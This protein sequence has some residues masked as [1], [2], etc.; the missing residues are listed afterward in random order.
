MGFVKFVRVQWD[1]VAGALCIVAGAVA[2]VVGWAQVSRSV[3]PAAQ[4]PY[5]VSCGVGGLFLLGVGA[6]LWL[7]ADLRDEWRHLDTLAD[8][9]AA[10]LDTRRADEATRSTPSASADF[11]AARPV[12]VRGGS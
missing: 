2:L 1:R 9:V 3:Y 11:P 8:R 4:F 12:A 10:R 5:L 7:S 6:T